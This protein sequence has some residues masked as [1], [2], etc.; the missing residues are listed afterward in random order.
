MYEK[1]NGLVRDFYDVIS[2]LESSSD[3]QV[4][5]DKIFTTIQRVYCN[6]RY[7]ILAYGKN[8]E[9]AIGSLA[10]SRD[11]CNSGSKLFAA[12][13]RT[14]QVA[15]EALKLIKV[16]PRY[17]RDVT[18]FQRDIERDARQSDLENKNR[19]L[20]LSNT[21]L[22][23]GSII[24]QISMESENHQLKEKVEELENSSSISFGACLNLFI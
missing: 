9:S 10:I 4:I 6:C 7:P 12:S 19:A 3:Q 20:E 1:N 8:L 13:S 22:A 14:L 16:H 15:Q 2:C 17:N 5:I 24:N 11:Q 18:L 23:V 21:L